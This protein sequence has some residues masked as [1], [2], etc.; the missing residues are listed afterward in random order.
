MSVGCG[1]GDTVF[2]GLPDYDALA[3]GMLDAEGKRLWIEA[4]AAAALWAA[5]RAGGAAHAVRASLVGNAGN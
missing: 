3:Q 4:G 1:P 2:A 5:E